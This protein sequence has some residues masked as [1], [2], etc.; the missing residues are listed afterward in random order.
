MKLV[1]REQRAKEAAKAWMRQY[2]ND[3]SGIGKMLVEL[4]DNPSPDDVNGLIGNDSWT[5]TPVCS[6]CGKGVPVVEV[7][8]PMN[9][10]S[11]WLCKACLEAALECAVESGAQELNMNDKTTPLSTIAI[12]PLVSELLETFTMQHHYSDDCWYTCPKHQ[13]GCCNDAEGDDC[14]CGADTYNAKLQE[15]ATKLQAR[16]SR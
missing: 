14:N 4:G 13:E 10:E 16:L 15:F 3:K 1:T 6:E 11:A 7:G 2:P 5:R 12:D 8:E 9:Y